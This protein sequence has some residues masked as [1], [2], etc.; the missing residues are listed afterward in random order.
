MNNYSKTAI[1]T[2][3][4]MSYKEFYETYFEPDY[5]RSVG[6][7]TFDNRKSSMRLHFAYFYKTQLKDINAVMLKKWQ[8][9]LSE[10]YS[11]P[12]FGMCTALFK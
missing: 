11:K 4:T 3:S 12:I 8:N 1:K 5:K 7:S 2:N 10:K 9:K 6:Q